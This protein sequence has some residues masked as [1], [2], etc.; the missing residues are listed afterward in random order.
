M[1]V[2]SATAVISAWPSTPP[3]L[4]ASWA[5]SYGGPADDGL[6]FGGDCMLEN[7]DGDL[8]VV[9]FTRSFAATDADLWV[10]R[11]DPDGEIRWERS[12]PAPGGEFGRAVDETPDGG[13]V[14]AGGPDP[15]GGVEGDAWVRKLQATGSVEW[16]RGYGGAGFDH[17]M[18]IRTTPPGGFIAAGLTD[19]SG[20]GGL[21]AWVVKLDASGNIEWEGAYGTPAD[22]GVF[23]V[24]RTRP[25]GG[26]VVAG[27]TD[28]VGTS[29]DAFI[30]KLDPLGVVEWERLYGT[31]TGDEWIVS[32]EQTEDQG[33]VAAGWTDSFGQG[34]SDFWVLRL[35]AAG[36]VLWQRCYGGASADEA[37]SVQP[38]AADG[39]FLVTGMSDS[40]DPDPGSFWVLK[41][42]A[43][44]D[45]EWQKL[46]GG[47]GDEVGRSVRLTADGGVALLGYTESF[48]GG[49]MDLWVLKLEPD[50]SIAA[51]CPLGA[52]T[53]VTAV[54]TTATAAAAASVVAVTSATVTDLPVADVQ[55]AAAVEQQ[56]PVARP[57]EPLPLYVSLSGGSLLLTFPLV[58]DATTYSGYRAEIPL[59]YDPDWSWCHRDVSDP[60]F[61]D[62]GDGTA[63][64]DCGPAPPGDVWYLVSASS[65]EA[66]SSLGWSSLGER[67][68]P[69]SAWRCGPGP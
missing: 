58:P 11:I 65:T 12:Y 32:I 33:Y 9:G 13:L 41:L 27:F 52:D 5:R 3:L 62:N 22:D 49:G 64:Y 15:F 18:S 25:G 66:E 16:A 19:S 44:G 10:L 47:P 35:D 29:S 2:V 57:P 37:W 46:Y 69:P 7:S 53:G 20:A 61:T 1:L 55:T 50:G 6:D 68:E 31:P 63:T 30:A 28:T 48:G 8:V 26:Y 40:F 38:V 4:G 54:D 24:R 51:P 43:A 17:F 45:V 39:G 56:C 23:A 67:D 42:S 34:G 14:V 60:S 36:D 21:D 59:Y